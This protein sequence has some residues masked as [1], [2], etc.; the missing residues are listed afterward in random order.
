MIKK[1][2]SKKSQDNLVGVGAYPAVVC[3]S[4]LFHSLSDLADT[5]EKRLQPKSFSN[6]ARL[7]RVAEFS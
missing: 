6:H 1:F 5:R 4:L 2:W 7:L 3:L